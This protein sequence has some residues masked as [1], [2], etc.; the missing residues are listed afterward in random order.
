MWN[1]HACHAMPVRMHTCRCPWN[2]HD[3]M[4]VRMHTCR[5]PWNPTTTFPTTTCKCYDAYAYLRTCQVIDMAAMYGH[6][7]LI[8]I[9][10]QNMD[11]YP[12]GRYIYIYVYICIYIL[13]QNMGQYPEGR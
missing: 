11:Q 9:L 2:L 8:V 4:P 3:A 13:D 1:M 6:E 12:E 7:R 5:C 10:D